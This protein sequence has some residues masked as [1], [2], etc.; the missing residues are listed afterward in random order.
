VCSVCHTPHNSDT[1][2]SVAPLWSHAQSTASSFQM[3][4]T[5][6]L[7]VQTSTSMKAT[8]LTLN[9]S[10]KLCLSCHDGTVAID[11]FRG[12]TNPSTSGVIS[13]ANNI[14][15]DLSNDHP[16]G[17]Q[18]S[19][20]L[21]NPT[22]RDVSYTANIGSSPSKTGTIATNLLLGGSVECSSCHDVHNTF[23]VGTSGM[24]KMAAANSTLCVTCHAK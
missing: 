12:N 19:A 7:G 3:Y 21:P 9:G 4:G 10:S 8:G 17:F 24:L 13:A 22:L 23:T 6:T 20:S 15:S 14:G 16:I 18:Y 11:N 1:S 5:N 2:V